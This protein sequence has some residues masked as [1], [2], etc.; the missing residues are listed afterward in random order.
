[1]SRLLYE[2]PPSTE[3]LQRRI[4]RLEQRVARLEA[5]LDAAGVRVAD[6]LPADSAR[7]VNHVR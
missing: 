6:P 2:A 4:H 7:V 3:D 1:M 5:A